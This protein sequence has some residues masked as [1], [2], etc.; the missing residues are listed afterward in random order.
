VSAAYTAAD[1][2]DHADRLTE[3]LEAKREQCIQASPQYTIWINCQI[4]ALSER[5]AEIDRQ[6][7]VLQRK[8]PRAG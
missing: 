7:R 3:L 4:K 1:L 2:A 6:C 5:L 8:T